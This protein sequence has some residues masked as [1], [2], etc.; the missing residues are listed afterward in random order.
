MSNYVRKRFKKLSPYELGCIVNKAYLYSV[1]AKIKFDMSDKDI[2]TEILNLSIMDASSRTHKRNYSL[3]EIYSYMDEVSTLLKM[4]NP[5]DEFA[6]N[7]KRE[8][9]LGYD[10][11]WKLTYMWLL[12]KI[13]NGIDPFVSIFDSNIINRQLNISIQKDGIQYIFDSLSKGNHNTFILNIKD[14]EYALIKKDYCKLK[15]LLLSFEHTYSVPFGFYSEFL[16][17][18]KQ[19]KSSINGIFNVIVG[20]LSYLDTKF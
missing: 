8:K 6:T 16:I 9:F 1:D 5:I 12:R 14:I 17:D 11:I 7:G 10:H 15:T 13:P 20:S 19:E 18:P 4:K 3:R 2:Q